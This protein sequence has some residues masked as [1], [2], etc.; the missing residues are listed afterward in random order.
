MPNDLMKLKESA[1]SVGEEKTS[2]IKIRP[3]MS[4]EPVKVISFKNSI[5]ENEE[6]ENSSS[7][8]RKLEEREVKEERNK[9][10]S[11]HSVNSVAVAELSSKRVKKDNDNI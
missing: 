8:S 11:I 3:S 6:K 2:T 10:N 4:P 7:K 9:L 5:S 1:T